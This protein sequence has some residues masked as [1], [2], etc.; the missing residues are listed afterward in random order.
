MVV[1]IALPLS[2]SPGKGVKSMLNVF[3]DRAKTS[4]QS[5]QPAVGVILI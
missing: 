1:F 2:N 4:L 5:Q 3:N